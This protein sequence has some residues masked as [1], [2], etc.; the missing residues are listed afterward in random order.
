MIGPRLW[1]RPMAND[2]I[3]HDKVPASRRNSSEISKKAWAARR[4]RCAATGLPLARK[5][6]VVLVPKKGRA[7]GKP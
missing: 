7:N 2:L 3:G 5:R 6:K 1:M 4:R